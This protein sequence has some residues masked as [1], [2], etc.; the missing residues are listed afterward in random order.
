MAMKDGEVS[1]H[2]PL[3]SLRIQYKQNELVELYCVESNET[4]LNCR[5]DGWMV[6]CMGG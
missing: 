5:M 4:M 1:A 6:G 3:L 2:W